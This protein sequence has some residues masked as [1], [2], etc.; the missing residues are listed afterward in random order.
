MA[1]ITVDE[2]NFDQALKENNR[3]LVDFWAEW[4]GPCRVIGPIV[5]QLGEEVE[6]LTVAKLNVDENQQLAEKFSVMSIPTLKLFENGK[7][8]K[9]LIG[10]RSYED[11]K[12]WVSE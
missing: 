11:L 4:C 10:L 7:E 8:V 12:S 6:G 9:T 2:K 3:V 1:T 5:E